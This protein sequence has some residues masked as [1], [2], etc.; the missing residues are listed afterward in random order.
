MSSAL[1]LPVL[2]MLLGFGGNRTL[3]P[4]VSQ[5]SHGSPLLHPRRHLVLG[6]QG[7]GSIRTDAWGRPLA[8]PPGS[9]CGSVDILLVFLL[10]V[11]ADAQ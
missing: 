11:L 9:L 3:F 5:C 4:S 8:S 7:L 10:L 6:G 1:S 2:L